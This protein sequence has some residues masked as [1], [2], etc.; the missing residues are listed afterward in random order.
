[1]GKV[2]VGWLFKAAVLCFAPNWSFTSEK[3]RAHHATKWQ[4][5]DLCMALNRRH[6]MPGAKSDG[7]GIVICALAVGL[8]IISFAGEFA[9]KP[10]NFSC[11]DSSIANPGN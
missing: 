7:Q 8:H 3:S 9:S 6:S 10:T 2:E 1:M 4:P 5:G 11:F